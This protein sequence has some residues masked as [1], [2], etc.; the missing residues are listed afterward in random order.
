[1]AAVLN[2]DFW[3]VWRYKFNQ[4]GASGPDIWASPTDVVVL[5]RDWN[6]NTLT[7]TGNAGINVS[8]TTRAKG[9]YTKD[10]IMLISIL[11]GSSA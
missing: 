4:G 5:Q 7:S 8:D 1:M 6:G 3:E 10:V 2:S 11:P 9:W